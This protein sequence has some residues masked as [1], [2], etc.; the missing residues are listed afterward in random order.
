MPSK[1]PWLTGAEQRAWR[2]WLAVSTA[3]PTE[4]NRLLLRDAG[5][6][7][8]DFGVLVQLSETTNRRAR[9]ADL[10]QLLQWE[11]SRLSHH[12]KRMEGRGLVVRESCG[13]DGRGAYAVLTDE[14]FAV[15]E[16]AAPGHAQAVKD[17][18][19]SSLTTE[20][21]EAFAAV[22]SKVLAHLSTP[23]PGEEEPPQET[24]HK[25]NL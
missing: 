17:I 1:S 6:H 13:A 20:E 7:W 15:L 5:L 4:L 18:M 2:N 23:N 21:L 19:F 14:G 12:I 16:S 3:L 22:T 10:A 25:E 11:R 8:Q 9:M 24:D